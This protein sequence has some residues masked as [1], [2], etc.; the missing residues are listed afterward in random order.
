MHKS[1]TNGIYNQNLQITDQILKAY[2]FL[3]LS[4]S[5]KTNLGWE[6]VFKLDEFEAGIPNADGGWPDDAV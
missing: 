4:L 2:L 6:H 3:S 5:L 1:H